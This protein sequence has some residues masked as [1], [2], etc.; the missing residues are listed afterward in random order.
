M[1]GAKVSREC[2]HCGKQF[3]GVARI[4]KL[5]KSRF[6]SVPCRRD[7]LRRPLRE[8]FASYVNK[9]GPIPAHCPEIGPCHVWTGGRNANGYGMLAVDGR[10]EI[11]ARVAWF[12]VHGRWPA[13][14]ALHKCDGGGLGC[15]RAD[16]LFEGTRA[17]NI[18]DMTAK[19]RRRRNSGVRGERNAGAKLRDADIPLIR[20]ALAEGDTQQALADQYCVSRSAIQLIAAGKNHKYNAL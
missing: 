16:H 3:L 1:N 5:G 11:A 17:D 14:C 4:V 12:L 18:A 6:C 8:R 20:A 13:P 9:N 15:V 2:E 7:G 10:A 19:G